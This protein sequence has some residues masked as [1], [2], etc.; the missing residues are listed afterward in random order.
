MD[1]NGGSIS[2][3]HPILNSKE[4]AGRNS[5]ANEIS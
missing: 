4:T 5:E 2:C 3:N 1:L